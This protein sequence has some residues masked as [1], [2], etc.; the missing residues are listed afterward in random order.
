VGLMVAQNGGH[1]KG[2]QTGAFLKPGKKLGSHKQT[3]GKGT[4]E[5]GALGRIEDIIQG[6]VFCGG[7]RTVAKE[8]EEGGRWGG[9]TGRREEK[10]NVNTRRP[11]SA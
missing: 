11:Q 4:H 6:N 2:G 8:Q 7:G 10:S 3:G 1:D 9:V 5:I